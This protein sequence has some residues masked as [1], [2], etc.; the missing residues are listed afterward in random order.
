MISGYGR[1][2]GKDEEAEIY[3]SKEGKKKVTEAE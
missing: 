2:R 3:Q 1:G